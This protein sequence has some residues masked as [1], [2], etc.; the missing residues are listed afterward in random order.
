MSTYIKPGFWTESKKNFKKFLNL[1]VFINKKID[2]KLSELPEA[3]TP[4]YKVYTALVNQTGTNEPVVTV[5]ENTLGMPLGISRVGVGNYN[6]NN[7]N[8]PFSYGKTV[9]FIQGSHDGDT[10]S[11]VIMEKLY[12][13]DSETVRIVVPYDSVLNNTSIEIRVYD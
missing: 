4:S 5:L 6:F 11:A 2:D 13:I 1:D 10:S 12:R 3:P 9:C 8:G 7:G